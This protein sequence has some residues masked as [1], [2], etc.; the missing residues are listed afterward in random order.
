MSTAILKQSLQKLLVEVSFFKMFGRQLSLSVEGEEKKEK[1]FK[2]G[3]KVGTCEG[4]HE[5]RHFVKL[6]VS[7]YR[8]RLVERV[9]GDRG[10]GT[11]C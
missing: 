8:S 4:D 11:K 3:A 6:R 5:R 10:P 1:R 7:A 2:P 9:K